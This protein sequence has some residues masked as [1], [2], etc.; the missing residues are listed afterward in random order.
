MMPPPP[1]QA[2]VVVPRDAREERLPAASYA[3]T[4]NV[5][6]V[7]QLRPVWLALGDATEATFIPSRK[8]SYPATPTS[9]VDAFQESVRLVGVTS[10]AASPLGVEGGVVSP[11]AAAG[12]SV[13]YRDQWDAVV[14]TAVEKVDGM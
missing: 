9:S 8:T 12:V 4:P 5:Y 10:D 13:A 3:S 1:W 11:P 6:E 2:A 14:L 7:P